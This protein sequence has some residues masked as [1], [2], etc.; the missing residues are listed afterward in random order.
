MPR[1]LRVPIRQ[2]R[3][4][5]RIT[6]AQKSLIERAAQLRGTT[7]TDYVVTKMQEAA[8]ETIR[9]YEILNLRDESR[10]LFVRALLNPPE[11]NDAAKTAAARYKKRMGQ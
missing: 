8:A 5:A 2:E 1:T 11:P 4:E 9:D 10:E 3:L 7:V 6:S